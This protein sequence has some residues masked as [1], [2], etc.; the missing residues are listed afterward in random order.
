MKLQ[1]RDQRVQ[2]YLLRHL[3]SPLYQWEAVTDPRNRR[4]IRWPLRVLLQ[5]ALVGML[6]ACRT[7]RDVEAL[8][9]EMKGT[10]RALVPGRVPDSTLYDLL[11]RLDV[12]QM[13]EQLRRQA[14]QM[15]RAKSLEPQGLPCGVLSIDGKQIG[16]LPHEAAGGAQK[17]HRSHDGSAYWLS[18]VS[19][20]VLTS[21]A[22]RPCLDQQIVPAHT[23]E[24]GLFA[25][26]FDAQ[27]RHHG[28]LFELVTADA[29]MTSLDNANRVH[30]A[31][32][33]YVLALKDN[34]PELRS[35]A[36]RILGPLTRQPPVAQTPWERVQGKW[37][38]RLL[39]R[40]LE[41][42]GYWGWGHLKQV[43][44]VRQETRSH[45]DRPT[46]C[47][48]G[49]K[50]VPPRIVQED[51]YFLSNL[52]PGR[53]TPQQILTV[54]RG[55]WGIEN[56]C[57]WSLDMQMHEDAAPWCTQGRALEVLGV[58]RLMAY[59]LLQLARK[60]HLRPRMPTGAPGEAPAW[61]RLLEW[62]RQALRL[63]LRSTLTAGGT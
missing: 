43:W 62:V 35:E 45:V 55:H 42:A 11:P 48:L 27:V 2:H 32:K 3:R 10:G 29:G 30:A 9:D 52:T 13:R 44:L 58:I 6:T 4:G 14:H 28:T 25:D 60:R 8:T 37:V 16:A 33:G 49:R 39:Y 21:A 53:L 12:E 26:F 59:N 19:R 18:R 24:M 20:A 56:D 7:L 38:R 46:A 40:T 34:Q 57:F 23:N 31:H 15:W 61:R 41:M 50:A 17:G 51:R 36:E 47:R 5:T 1:P 63:P 22:S 54:V